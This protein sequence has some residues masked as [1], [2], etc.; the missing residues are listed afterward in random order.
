MTQV[1]GMVL[2]DLGMSEESELS[3]SHGLNLDILAEGT[4]STDAVF[5]FLSM[6]RLFPNPYRIVAYTSLVTERTRKPL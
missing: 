2:K 4:H 3:V 6:V 1:R 5:Q